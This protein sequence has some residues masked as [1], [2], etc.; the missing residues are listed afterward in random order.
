MSHRV[1]GSKG[2]GRAAWLEGQIRTVEF[3]N[4]TF[5]LHFAG[6]VQNLRTGLVGATASV[7]PSYLEPRGSTTVFRSWR[8]QPSTSAW[9]PS[10]SFVAAGNSVLS[11]DSDELCARDVDVSVPIVVTALLHD[12][13][14]S[15][16]MNGFLAG[17]I[18]P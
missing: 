17:R 16:V 18:A 12:R 14:A 10:S 13:S 15:D 11:K 9:R 4:D 6:T 1:S 2:T 5:T 3:E 8:L 7:M